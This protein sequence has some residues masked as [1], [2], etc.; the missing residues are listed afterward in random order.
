M[1]EDVATA[2]NAL[3]ESS[4]VRYPGNVSV[5]SR[6]VMASQTVVKTKIILMKRGVNK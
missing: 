3:K 2:R 6:G 4:N 5:R 1:S